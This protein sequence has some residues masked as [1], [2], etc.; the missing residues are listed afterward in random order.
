MRPVNLIERRDPYRNFE[1]IVT[2]DG[3]GPVAACR[4]VSGLLPGGETITFREGR[5]DADGAEV[6]DIVRPA[7]RSFEPV[8]LESGLT[9]DPTFVRW[10]NARTGGDMPL[11]SDRRTVVIQVRDVENATIAR[12]FTLHRAWVSKFTAL[13]DL[14]GDANELLIESVQIEHEGFTPKP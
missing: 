2:W 7:A 10:A 3:G 6:I 9:H 5:D 12:A 14:A 1:F 13:S 4:K 11:G 8:T